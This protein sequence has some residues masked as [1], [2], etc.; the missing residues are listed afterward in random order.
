MVQFRLQDITTLLYRDGNRVNE[1]QVCK[2][3]DENKNK[4]ELL[5]VSITIMLV[6]YVLLLFLLCYNVIQYVIRQKRYKV[7]HLTFFYIMSFA[8]VS[9]RIIFFS[10]ILE[11][12]FVAKGKA[13]YPP[14]DIGYIDN[15]ATYTELILGIQ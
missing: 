10:L 9:L 4:W 12:L 14:N 2:L 5:V 3:E 8:I 6:I 11:F 7:F 15:F 13:L 1:D